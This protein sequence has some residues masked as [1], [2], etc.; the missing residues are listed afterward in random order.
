MTWFRRKPKPPPWP[1]VEVGGP[2]RCQV[3]MRTPGAISSFWCCDLPVDH[4]GLLHHWCIG[5]Q[6]GWFT[7]E[8]AYASWG[9]RASI[10]EIDA[11]MGSTE[12]R[13]HE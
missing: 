8:D 1:D 13:D 4:R 6:E 2:D 10:A 12:W 5:E 11:Y 9:R 7:T 3:K